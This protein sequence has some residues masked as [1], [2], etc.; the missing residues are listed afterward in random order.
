MSKKFEITNDTKI[1]RHKPLARVSHW[2]LV[3]SFM[4]MFTGVAFFF[5]DFAWLTEILG[6][7]QIARA[8]HPFTGIIM[9]IAFI[10]MALIY[11]HHNIPEKNDIR[12]A[13]GIVEVLR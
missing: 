10:I 3:I 7:P 2:F 1:V 8:V 6:T 12:W 5:P 4:T 9:F 13:K 11:W